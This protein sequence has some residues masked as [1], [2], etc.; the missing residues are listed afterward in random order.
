MHITSYNYNIIRYNFI[1]E[2]GHQKI[3]WTQMVDV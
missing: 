3:I 2:G 1:E